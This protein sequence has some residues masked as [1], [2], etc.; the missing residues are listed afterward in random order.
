MRMLGTIDLEI[1][2]L[3]ASHNKSITDSIIENSELKRLGV[4][5]ILDTLASLRDRELLSLDNKNGTFTMTDAAYNI[6]WSNTVPLAIKILRLLE[7]QSCTIQAISSSL[8]VKFDDLNTTLTTLQKEQYII[9]TPQMRKDKVEKIY[10]ITDKGIQEIAAD[11]KDSKLWGNTST[12]YT[13]DTINPLN[14][15]NEITHIIS[16]SKS[17]TIEERRLLLLKLSG[18]H[19]TLKRSTKTVE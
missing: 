1:L 11:N 12:Q 7:I 8:N 17:I 13:N 14:I 9:I 6:L 19:D 18:L 3:A 4:G 16:T 10:E 5:K 15:I 2:Q